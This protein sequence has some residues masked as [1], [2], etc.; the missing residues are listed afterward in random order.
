MKKIISLFFTFFLLTSPAIAGPGDV[1]LIAKIAPKDDAFVGMVDADQVIGGEEE[2]HAF[3][4]LVG[5][6]DTVFPADP[7]ADRYLMWN[8]GLGE[9]VWGAGGGS[10]SQT[11]WTSDINAAGYTLIGGTN[12]TDILKLHG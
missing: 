7:N 9:L 2:I 5:G 3:E 10:G 8:D 12:A 4:H 6:D 1:N 11:P